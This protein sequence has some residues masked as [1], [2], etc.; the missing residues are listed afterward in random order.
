MKIL[1]YTHDIQ[2]IGGIET[3]FYQFAQWLKIKGYEVGVRYDWSDPLQV[4]RYR[5]AGIDFQPLKK[6][7]ADIL[8]VGSIWKQPQQITARL[9][10]QQVHADWSD[11]YWSKDSGVELIRKAEKKVDVFAAVSESAA[12][13]VRQHTSKAVIV[14]NNLAPDK[15]L[16]S[17]SKQP[18]TV[19]AAFTRMTAEK[20]LKNYQT[21]REHVLSMGI[22]AEFRVFTNGDAPKGW[23]AYEPVVDITKVLGEVDY[24]CSL[25]D[26]ESFGYTIAE[27]Q[28]CGVRTIIKK[29]NSTN[30]FFESIVLENIL[31]L[32]K[33]DL[34]KKPPR[35]RLRGQ[36]EDNI[37]QAMRKLKAMR[38]D[39]QMLRVTRPFTDL[40]A[41]TY[42]NLGD[43]FV[44]DKARA[45]ELLSNK[46]KIVVRT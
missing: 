42:R 25:A 5:Q 19:F 24:V 1:L 34:K 12:Q 45:K 33:S 27:A 18:K 21:L 32:K 28:S 17:R 2:K 29:A 9:V 35:Y 4:K 39:R 8:I 36:T 15:R 22:D 23:E 40:T 30:E 43:T 7:S 44:A 14:M 37:I 31:D 3:S 46:A 38:S 41:M 11:T 6:E 20:G 16:I 13:F 26:T 10:V